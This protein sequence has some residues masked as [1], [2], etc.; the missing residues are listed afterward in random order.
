MFDRN[1][2]GKIP[3]STTDV[4]PGGGIGLASCTGRIGIMSSST[5]VGMMFG[6]IF[7]GMFSDIKGRRQ[8]FNLTLG[9]TCFFG[10]ATSFSVSFPMLCVMLLLL[11]FGLGGSMVVDGA[12]F[13]EFIPRKYQYL[14]TF[15]SIF[16]SFGALFA[17]VVAV[18]VV[19]PFSCSEPST[20]P[21]K[22]N[23]WRYLIGCMA[24]A[25]L[26]MVL[27]RVVFFTLPESPKYLLNHQR[28]EEA[29][30]VLRNI[31]KINQRDPKRGN[32]A[33]NVDLLSAQGCRRVAQQNQRR[34][35][36]QEWPALYSPSIA[37]DD[38][39]SSIPQRG[40]ATSGPHGGYR[41]AA[42]TS[43]EDEDLETGRRRGGGGA[44]GGGAGIVG[45]GVAVGG[46]GQLTPPGSPTLSSSEPTSPSNSTRPLAPSR[47]ADPTLGHRFQRWIGLKWQLLRHRMRPMF[48]RKY[49][50]TTL[51]IWAIW[52]LVAFGFTSF[53]VF[54]PKYMQEHGATE[55]GQRSLKDVYIDSAIYSAAGVPGSV[56]AV[57]LIE[58]RLGRRY[59]MAA[60][61]LG[62]AA[63]M[64]M[65]AALS[66]R[67]AMVT[68]SAIV[69]LLA[70][71]NYAVLYSYT[72]EVFPSQ[73]R[74]TACGMASA[75]SRL[76]GVLAPLVAGALLS[77]S[78]STP[79]Y[80]AAATFLV[81]TVCMC[82]LPV[83]TRGKAAM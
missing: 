3:T 59:T 36:Q 9:V 58:G 57:V 52:A 1:R 45:I 44:G 34:D 11:G 12:L 39:D 69:S 51:L 56:I 15:L 53:N 4:A 38:S 76:T 78:T 21:C 54:L 43:D 63:A 29:A 14:L 35:Q 28:H 64:S 30:V 42:T 61:T 32:F 6:A 83:E 20:E 26:L 73:F 41:P 60:S 2:V 10:F 77:V 50:L 25:T 16:F 80:V 70:T 24:G 27:G 18:F 33:E 72:P 49:R 82:L 7:W 68:F 19:P 71:L 79:L 48:T 40:G 81:S 62:T 66:S 74:G 22:G 23:G 46:G 55:E 13:L 37:S 31:F 65:F 75:L 8:A 67:T 47:P 5:F 17:S